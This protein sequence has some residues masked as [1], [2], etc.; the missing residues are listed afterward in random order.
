[1]SEITAM[2]ASAIAINLSRM[3]EQISMSILKANAQA[4]QAVADIL[5]NNARQVEAL[6]ADSSGGSVDIYL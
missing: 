4:A 5:T 1:M 2:A 3:Q 6:S